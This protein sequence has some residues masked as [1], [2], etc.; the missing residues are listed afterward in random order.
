MGWEHPALGAGHKM[1]SQTTLPLKYLDLGIFDRTCCPQLLNLPLTGAHLA[2][3]M[4][5]R[6]LR[7]VLVDGPL[8]KAARLQLLL[9]LRPHLAQVAQVSGH[10]LELV[11][12]VPG[13]E[14]MFV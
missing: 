3:L 11:P 7:A 9:D 8:V 14:S 4:G 12:G 10:Q 2:L 6:P 1:S 13:F 5:R